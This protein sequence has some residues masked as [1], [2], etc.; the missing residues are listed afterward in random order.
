MMSSIVRRYGIYLPRLWLWYPWGV[1]RWGL[2]RV[3]RGGDEWCNTPRCFTI[4]PFGMLLVFQFW[5][6]M[7]AE[8]CAV[9]WGQMGIDQRAD[10]LPGGIY[11]GGKIRAEA[12]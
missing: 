6:P 4:A 12:A 8:P 7:R 9:C 10:Y 2:P 3:W 1:T 5:R 11:H